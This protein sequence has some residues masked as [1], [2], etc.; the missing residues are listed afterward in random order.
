LIGVRAV[1]LGVAGGAVLEPRRG[2]IMEGRGVRNTDDPGIAVALQA[3]LTHLAPLEQIRVV[4]AVRRM[5]D[6]AAFYF[7]RRVLE[8]KGALLISMALHADGISAGGG[9]SLF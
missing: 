6:C 2:L 3:E 4:G 1:N 7:G 5:A 9:S 8:Y